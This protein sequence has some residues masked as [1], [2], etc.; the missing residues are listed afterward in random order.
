MS[1]LLRIFEACNVELA[2]RAARVQWDNVISASWDMNGI[3]C[4][5]RTA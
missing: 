5:A 3:E 1:D 4:G 2:A